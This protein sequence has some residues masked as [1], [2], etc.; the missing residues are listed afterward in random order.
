MRECATQV[1]RGSPQSSSESPDVEMG[2]TS[3]IGVGDK[4]SSR[5]R[6]TILENVQDVCPG[7]IRIESKL[8]VE[9]GFD[10]SDAQETH[11][12]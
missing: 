9:K 6:L 8:E 5:R 12:R 1:V 4:K 11:A 2:G 10:V 3:Y 7:C